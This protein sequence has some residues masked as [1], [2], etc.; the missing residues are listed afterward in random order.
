MYIWLTSADESKSSEPSCSSALSIAVTV[1]RR[2]M[3]RSVGSPTDTAV[4]SISM[5]AIGPPRSR[6]LRALASMLRSR[7]KTRRFS[8]H[9]WSS[10]KRRSCSDS[11]R[12]V[13]WVRSLASIQSK[14]T[15]ASRS[16]WSAISSISRSR[17]SRSV[18]SALALVGEQEVVERLEAVALVGLGDAV[19]AAQRLVEEGAL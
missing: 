10:R 3:G 7:S 4:S 9:T 11:N 16:S 14:W 1:G 2:Y 13:A 17:S 18:S 19:A 5:V 12:T 15:W 8:S 6:T